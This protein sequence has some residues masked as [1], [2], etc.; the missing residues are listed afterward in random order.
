MVKYIY[1]EL[2][3]VYGN[4]GHVKAVYHHLSKPALVSPDGDEYWYKDGL[5]HR[6]GDFPAITFKKKQ[7]YVWMKE[8]KYHRENGPA[9]MR[10]DGSYEWYRNGKLHREGGP[11][12]YDP[13]RKIS[14]FWIDG[15]KVEE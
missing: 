11:A 10:P 7:I 9:I 3:P 2:T 14:E 12:L 15:V 8:G 6:E 5:L 13:K 4:R 1:G